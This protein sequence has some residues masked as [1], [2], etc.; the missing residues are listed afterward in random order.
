MTEQEIR[1]RVNKILIDD[2]EL[3]ET[4]LVPEAN[5]RD[6]LGLDSLDGVD[7]IVALEK[8][9][10]VKIEESAARQIDTVGRI[11]H[12]IAELTQSR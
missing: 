1:E 10:K 9:F 5:L 8:A 2:F 12:Q 7:L 3:P 11:Y 6:E 4:K